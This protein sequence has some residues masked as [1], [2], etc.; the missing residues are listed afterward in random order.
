MVISLSEIVGNFLIFILEMIL[1][2]L[3]FYRN[4]IESIFPIE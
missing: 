4:F 2:G 1:E 3:I